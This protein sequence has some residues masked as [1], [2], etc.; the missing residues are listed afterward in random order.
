M[1][2]IGGNE[3]NSDEINAAGRW[4]DRILN[5]RIG[6]ALMLGVFLAFG[7]WPEVRE[8]RQNTDV[9][10]RHMEQN[11]KS[12]AEANHAIKEILGFMKWKHPKIN[13]E[14]TQ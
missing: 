14:K 9:I 13:E 11:D 6:L 2:K 3:F 10:A 12:I 8:I 4:F 5:S 1:G 7:V